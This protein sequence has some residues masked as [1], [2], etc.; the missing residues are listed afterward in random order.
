LVQRF[1][2]TELWKRKSY[3][4]SCLSFYTGT[5][6]TSIALAHI[7]HK[8]KTFYLY[9]FQDDDDDYRFDQIH[10]KNFIKNNNYLLC[11]VRKDMDVNEHERLFNI[12][13]RHKFK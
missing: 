6:V 7:I 13:L 4:H 1:F 8:D 9:I 11:I 3:G 5:S 10:I 2:Y 12:T